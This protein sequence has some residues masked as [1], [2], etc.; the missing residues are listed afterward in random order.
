MQRIDGAIARA[1]PEPH[2]A[3]EE[4][5]FDDAQ[6]IIEPATELESQLE[7]LRTGWDRATSP[8]VDRG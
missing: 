3:V 6:E 2:L 5:R 4:G 7:R 8:I 1:P